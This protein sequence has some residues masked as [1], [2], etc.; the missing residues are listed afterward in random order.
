MGNS[1]II[2]AG[3]TLIDLTSDTVSASNLASGI[4]AH[5]KTGNQITGT[6]QLS[7]SHSFTLSS[8]T[9]T[10]SDG[11]IGDIWVVGN[12]GIISGTDVDYSISTN[13]T[14]Y[15]GALDNLKSS[16]TSTY[17]WSGEEQSI[18]KYV[19]WTFDTPV[20]L[21][22]VVTYSSN[23]GDRPKTNQKLQVSSDNS[24]WTDCGTFSNS[25]TN[26]F[27]GTWSDIQYMR[28]Y[29]TTAASYW[30]YINYVTLTYTGSDS[31]SYDFS[32]I[33]QKESSGWTSLSDFSALKSGSW[34]F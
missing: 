27:S 31:W 12:G 20:T 34:T 11:N 26:T 33:Y 22:K 1:K 10:S 6:A 19:L 14:T 2:Y 13:Y 17:W 18:G 7:A 5:D 23:S 21:T 16:S 15:A 25:S 9:P 24:T 3:T 8:S 28:I 32:K 29:C 30:L 4:T